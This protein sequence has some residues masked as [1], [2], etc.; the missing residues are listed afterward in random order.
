MKRILAIIG[1]VFCG[2]SAFSQYP[3]SQSIGADSTLVTSKGGLKGRIINWSFT[4]TSSANLQPIRTYAGAMI[5]TTQ[6]SSV[7]YRIPNKWI[8]ILPYGT[9]HS[10]TTYW[11]LQGNYVSGRLAQPVLGTTT[12][13]DLPFITNN[14]QRAT[15]P[16][17][18]IKR[19][20]LSNYKYLM[21]DTING[22]SHYIAYGDATGGGAVLTTNSVGYGVAGVLSGGNKLTFDGTKFNVND[23]ASN[24][25]FEVDNVARTWG[26]GDLGGLYNTTYVTGDDVTK[27]VI[28]AAK[29]IN[30][31]IQPAGRLQV[32]GKL[33]VTDSIVATGIASTALDTTTNKILVINSSTGNVKKS[34]WPTTAT[35]T[36]QQ[37]TTAGNTT[38]N[39][40]NR[41]VGTDT[42]RI[43]SDHGVNQM[44]F[45]HGADT[46]INF[47]SSAGNFY[48]DGEVGA[49][50][51]TVE[52]PAHLRVASIKKDSLTSG[53][54]VKS[55]QLPDSTGVPVMFINGVKPDKKGQVTISTGS[56]NTGVGSGYQ[57]AIN[58]TNNIKSLT[59]GYGLTADSATSNQVNYKV[60]SATLSTKY[61]RLADTATMLSPYLRS[62]V[63]AATYL[64]LVGANYGT[65]TGT[66]LALTSST[67]TTGNLMS[68]TNTGTVATSNTKNVLSIVSSGAN[69]T[70]SQTVTGQTISVTNTG[71]TNTNVGLNVTASGAT[72]NYAALFTGNVG[73][74]TTAPISNLNI[75]QATTGMKGLTITGYGYN[76]SSSSSTT[77]GVAFY[78][79]YNNTSN[80]QIFMG[81]TD[82][83]GSSTL[84]VIRLQT[85]SLLPSI[86][87]SSGDGANR[88]NFSLGTNTTNVLVGGNDL[89]VIQ[90]PHKLT[91]MNGNTLKSI[92]TGSGATGS[93][94]E[95]AFIDSSGNASI[96]GF[97]TGYVAKTANYT[98]TIS[99]HTIEATSG[100]FT[101][102]LPT[103]V[104]ATGQEYVITNS[105][106]GVVT[107]GTTSSQTF[108][109][110]TA[111]PT[112][113]T[114]AQFATVKVQSNGTAWL[115]IT[116]L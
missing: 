114:L 112:T 99:D 73:I 62:N 88:V 61:N 95:K 51:F 41:T 71:T 45:I 74:G 18:G 103:A 7:W 78:M 58:G 25:M 55:F 32:A 40:I 76:A 89:G 24:T 80:R 116:S 44:L 13:A 63:G 91:V 23:G 86:D 15:I 87:A 70:A 104:G 109:N 75:N 46:V 84:G 100:T 50:V 56:P 83:I 26:A 64:P 107:L 11:N 52:D 5:Y 105:G 113:L 8:Q 22:G 92:S 9:R 42:I 14:I 48:A 27:M 28:V 6:D 111:T 60:D 59:S 115:R 72:N 93:Y 2:L 31:N 38:T 21:I 3:V 82:A 102:T 110:V 39:D 108:I 1:F 67:V 54:S 30:I 69:G 37:V 34:Y 77:Q 47:N 36:L 33:L 90:P 20:A 19:T 68:L 57:V 94:V 16:Q 12:S 81:A 96:K 79:N 10:D 29:D 66:G 85:G 49:N 17:D 43:N 35:P 97:S 106:T 4:D 101:I 98:A 53:G 65:T